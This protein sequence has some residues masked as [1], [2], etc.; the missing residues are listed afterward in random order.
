MPMNARLRGPARLHNREHSGGRCGNSVWTGIERRCQ[1]RSHSSPES[2]SSG[3][4]RALRWHSTQFSK[5]RMPNS[6]CSGAHARRCV[7]E[8]AIADEISNVPRSLGVVAIRSRPDGVVSPTWGSMVWRCLLTL[9]IHASAS[10]LRCQDPMSLGSLPSCK[11]GGRCF[12]SS[13]TL[14]HCQK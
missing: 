2:P 8:T 14:G 13:G 7:L 6:R 9:P 4:S 3:S 11:N 5:L 1:S 12:D 10:H